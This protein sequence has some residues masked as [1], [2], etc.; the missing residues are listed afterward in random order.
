[1]LSALS[2]Q[3]ACTRTTWRPAPS[4]SSP[5]TASSLRRHI[6]VPPSLT[7]VDVTDAIE[8][9]GLTGLGNR[10]PSRTTACTSP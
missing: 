10:A 2:R 9:A 7:K 1:M 6:S 3:P 8:P 4:R 5:S